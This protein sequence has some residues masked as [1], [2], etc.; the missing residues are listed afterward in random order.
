M[1]T[2]TETQDTAP[3]QPDIVTDNDRAIVQ[4]FLRRNVVATKKENES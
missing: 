2:K 4:D 1:V 3:S